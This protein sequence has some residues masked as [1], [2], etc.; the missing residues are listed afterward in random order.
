MSEL[1]MK[2]WMNEGQ[3]KD[4]LLLFPP[5]FGDVRPPGLS[6]HNNTKVVNYAL[7]TRVHREDFK[8]A[9][10]NDSCL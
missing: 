2:S 5:K 6:K 3:L 7:S 10:E 4:F 8:C 9:K 1:S